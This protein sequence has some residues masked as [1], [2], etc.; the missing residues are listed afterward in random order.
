[1]E[2]NEHFKEFIEE[3]K[4][5]V[6]IDHPLVLNYLGYMI[7]KTW[8]ERPGFLIEKI[9]QTSVLT[10]LTMWENENIKHTIQFLVHITS[11][12]S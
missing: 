7:D 5:G 1:M 4:E 12:Q 2:F 9:T 10:S 8:K 11:Q 6:T 3:G